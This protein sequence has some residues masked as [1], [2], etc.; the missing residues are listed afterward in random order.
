MIA[1]LP[2]IAKRSNWAAE[3]WAKGTGLTKEHTKT[4]HAGTWL[5]VGGLRGTA[6]YGNYDMT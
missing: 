3:E 6:D 2:A 1:L 4:A 5:D